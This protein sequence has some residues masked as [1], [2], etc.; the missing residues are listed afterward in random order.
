M[1]SDDLTFARIIDELIDDADSARAF[2]RDMAE[3]GAPL[4]EATLRGWRRG[5]KPSRPAH[6][7]VIARMS[8]LPHEDVLRAALGDDERAVLY[9][10]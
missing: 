4:T 5:A 10:A 3:A 2:M 6:L 7:I 8:G 9:P 1:A